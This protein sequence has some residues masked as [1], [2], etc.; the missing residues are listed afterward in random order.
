MKLIH[1]IIAKDKD[2]LENH[3]AEVLSKGFTEEERRDLIKAA[4]YL[5]YAADDVIHSIS[6]SPSLDRK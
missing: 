6:S 4:L 2:L 5:K 3:L 1:G